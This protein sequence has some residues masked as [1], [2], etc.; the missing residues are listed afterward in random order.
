MPVKAFPCA[1]ITTRKAF[2]GWSSADWRTQSRTGR[3]T[4][5]AEAETP[6]SGGVAVL[7]NVAVCVICLSCAACG[8]S[9]NLPLGS[10]S[11]AMIPA[12]TSDQD[13]SAYLIGPLD[14][15]NIAVFREPQLSAPSLQ[16]DAGGDIVIPLLGRVRAAGK[17]AAD[18]SQEIEAGLRRYLI[19]PSVAVNVNSVRQ[20]IAVEGG[21]NQPGIYQIP[22]KTTLLEAI[23]L[24]RSPSE[25]AAQDQVLVFR[26]IDGRMA[27][28]RFDIRRIRMGLDPDPVILAGDRVVVGFDGLKEAWRDYFS[29]GIFNAFR[30]GIPLD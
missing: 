24:A 20:T 25:V 18:L 30:F 1:S 8:V 21:V 5:N 11:Y 3:V 29:K 13:L 26:K 9:S 15:L 22:G 12:T 27:A 17:S 23:A 10:A 7:K 4:K 16:V 19:N 28:A 6:R 2:E 14:T